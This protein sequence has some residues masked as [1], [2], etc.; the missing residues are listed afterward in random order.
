[1]RLLKVAKEGGTIDDTK[2]HNDDEKY[3]LL[4]EHLRSPIP[5]S[6][7]GYAVNSSASK[8]AYR[9]YMTASSTL[10]RAIRLS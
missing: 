1:M 2:F 6:P 9:A 8:R 4:K 10:R 7:F 5:L 3:T